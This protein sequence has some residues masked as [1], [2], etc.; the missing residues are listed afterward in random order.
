MIKK[1][2]P[3]DILYEF[4][5]ISLAGSKFYMSCYPFLLTPM[6]S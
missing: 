2:S 4:A 1:F 5:L 3:V 6:E